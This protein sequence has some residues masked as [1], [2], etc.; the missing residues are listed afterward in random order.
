[1]LET[2]ECVKINNNG[3]IYTDCM[4]FSLLR[5][6]QLIIYDSNQIIDI[7]KSKYNLDLNNIN[8]L[9]TLS[10]TNFVELKSFIDTYPDIYQK[11]QYYL[12]D[13]IGLK[14]REEWSKLVSDRDFFDYYR[15]DGAELFT[16]VSNVINFF[17]GFFSLNL[18]ND[19]ILYQHNLDKI[20]SKF[21]SLN[22][23]ISIIK[24]EPDIIIRMMNLKNIL[25]YFSRPDTDYI[26]NLNKNIEYK[27][28]FKTTYLDLVIDG[29][30]Y[31][32]KLYEVYLDDTNL[33]DFN[34]INKFIT[35]HSV[36]YNV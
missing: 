27:V 31:K 16:S 26:N 1:M 11:A 4:E 24:S 6:F 20:A 35:G 23:K 19:E 32:W 2:T 14:Q 7:G 13:K 36:I 5:F 8:G 15:N 22:K 30:N 10:L 9:D 25:L 3:R 17:N 12:S 21:S 33:I 28:V 18:S 34:L 29:N